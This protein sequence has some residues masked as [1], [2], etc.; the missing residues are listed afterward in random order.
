VKVLHVEAGRHLYGGA[1]Q[2]L[3]L[4]Q[5]LRAGDPQSEHLLVCPPGSATAEEA[6]RRGLAVRELPLGGEADAASAWRLAR[7]ARRERV[8]LLHAHSRRGADLWSGMAGCIAARPV[9]L[10]RRV[11]NPESRLLVALKYRLFRHV[12]TISEGIRQV[13]LAEGL[14]AEKLTRVASAVDTE[15]YRPDGDRQALLAEFGLPAD[16]VPVAVIAQ[17]IERKG[18]RTLLQ[19]L[20]T[21]LARV[22]R[23]RLL[24]FG[25]GPLEAALRGEVE[26]AG[27]DEVVIFAG[28]R[29]DLPRLLPALAMVV[30]PAS[31]EGLGVALLQAAAC[32]IPV[33]ACRSGGIPEVVRD[34]ENG[35]L[36][37]PRDA[38][39]L[40]KAMLAILG[41]ST[42]AKSM[43]R[44]GREIVQ[45]EFS[46]SSMV[47]GNLAVYRAVLG[48]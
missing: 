33:V 24:V 38:W 40:A 39:A 6:V 26:N 10:T 18:H 11:D 44:R 7:L 45:R 32:A 22:P 20:P 15:L 12:I 21:V 41:D 47:A 25:R 28:F 29:D 23:M 5:G 19:A 43:G 31:M 36:V 34:G 13:L 14:A 42:R 37:P 46:I 9:V 4:L 16:A 27:L 30:H 1:L 8:D 48:D 17:L 35:L 2:V 3:F